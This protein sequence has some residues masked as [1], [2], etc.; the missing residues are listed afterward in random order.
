MMNKLQSSGLLDSFNIKHYVVISKLFGGHIDSFNYNCLSLHNGRM[1]CQYGLLP[2]HGK[3]SVKDAGEISNPER[4]E[5][6]M[7]LLN[8]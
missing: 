3:S 7:S 8:N 6:L 5:H 2:S 1:P 4:K